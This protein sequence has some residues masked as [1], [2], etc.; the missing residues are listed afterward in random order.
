MK[1][2]VKAKNDIVLSNGVFLRGGRVMEVEISD[3]DYAFIT[4]FITE[5]VVPKD[6]KEIKPKKAKKKNELA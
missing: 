5:I 4:P 3:K 6:E 1:H 2:I